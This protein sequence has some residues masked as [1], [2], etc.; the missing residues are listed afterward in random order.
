MAVKTDF[1]EL[2]VLLFV[3]KFKEGVVV[4]ADVDIVEGKSISDKLYTEGYLEY[5]LKVAGVPVY[6]ISKKGENMI[7]LLFKHLGVFK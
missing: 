1:D 7:Q 4:P 5:D 6:K 2:V 3:N